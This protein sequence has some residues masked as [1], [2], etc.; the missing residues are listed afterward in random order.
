MLWA[1]FS[2]LAALTWSIVNIIDKYVLTKW[3]RRPIVP[4]MILGIIGLIASVIV[5]FIRGFSTLSLLNISWAF[6]AGF[7]YI[8][9]TLLYFKAVKLEEIS[10]IIP[11]FYLT[12]LFI[13]I[14]ASVQLSFQFT[15]LLYSKLPH[16]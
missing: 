11:L 5:Y 15:S 8:I 6:I 1:L 4:V 2:I 9:M 16:I 14:L 12:P 10:R 13:L 7:F 3:V